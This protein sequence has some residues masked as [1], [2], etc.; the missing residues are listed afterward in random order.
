MLSNEAAQALL[1]LIAKQDQ[2]AFVVFYREMSRSIYVFSLNQLKNAADSEDVVVET[3]HEVWRCAVRFR[4]ES[5]VSTWVLGIARNKLLM[6]LRARRDTSVDVDELSETLASES[7]DPD[8]LIAAAQQA[9]EVGRCMQKLSV[10]H[11]EC[12]HLTFFEDMSVAEVAR[13]QQV[14]EGTVKTRLFHARQKI[15]LCLANL[16]RGVNVAL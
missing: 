5:K 13:L 16:L 15:K 10:V 6:K 4:G 3:M 9:K 8:E 1:M 2:S 14:P 11:R 12:L 7:P